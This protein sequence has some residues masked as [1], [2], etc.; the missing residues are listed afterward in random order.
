MQ[1][2]PFYLWGNKPVPRVLSFGKSLM[3][4]LTMNTSCHKMRRH[5][6]GVVT[7]KMWL[8]TYYSLKKV[9][10]YILLVTFQSNIL[11]NLVTSYLYFAYE[12]VCRIS[13]SL[14]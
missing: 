3:P 1:F 5:Q 11:H 10:Y 9:I 2:V 12:Y 14:K 6:V 4:K 13:F 7:L 8:V